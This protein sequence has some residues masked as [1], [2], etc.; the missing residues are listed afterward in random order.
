MNEK[1]FNIDTLFITG[2]LSHNSLYLQTQSDVTGCQVV[3]SAESNAVLIGSSILG[4]VASGFYKNLTEA[5]SHMNRLGKVIEPTK[6]KE[7]IQYHKNKYKVF[8]KM[9]EDQLA[10]KKIMEEQ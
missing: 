10:Y 1:G 5:M 2:G 7:L 4:A 8:R 6:D 3:C 9:C